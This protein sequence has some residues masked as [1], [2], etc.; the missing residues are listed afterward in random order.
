MSAI[1]PDIADGLVQ[2][3]Q[4]FDELRE[5]PDFHAPLDHKAFALKRV[6]TDYHFPKEIPC[7]LK[8]CRQPHMH[9]YLVLTDGGGETNIGQRCGKTH[10]GEEVFSSA[11]ADYV[12]RR[13]REELV[14]RAK[15]LQSIAPVIEA[16]IR[17][18]AF[19]QYGAKWVLRVKKA[20]EDA[21]GAG[22][23]DSLRV[24]SLRGDLVVA[25]SRRRT[26][27]EID[28]LV[29]SNRGLSRER[30]MYAEELIGE[31][32]PMP[33]IGYDFQ[34]KLMVN[35]LG[36]LK[37]FAALDAASLASPKLKAAIKPFENYERELEDA[38]ESAASAMRFLAEDNLRLV[39]EW[40][41]KHI[42]GAAGA[43]RAWIGG[44]EH[45]ELLHGAPK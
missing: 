3:P 20:M 25:R 22:L 18:L 31:L 27:E 2:R 17:E 33:W 42:T 21:I 11:R 5:R 35:L 29:A 36:P 1:L 24:A 39:A 15:H 37:P 12:R 8:S 30:A 44:K 19:R 28:D 16:A 7:G 14:A 9:G 41:P 40:I 43:L 13:E 4:S 26:D 32:V 10:F 23:V 45:R 38:G 6:L 34:T